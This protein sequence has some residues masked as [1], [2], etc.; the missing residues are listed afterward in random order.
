MYVTRDRLEDE[1]EIIRKWWKVGK[2][3]ERERCREKRREESFVKLNGRTEG[4]GGNR[5]KGNGKIE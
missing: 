3:V 2:R 4:N 5:E 1:G